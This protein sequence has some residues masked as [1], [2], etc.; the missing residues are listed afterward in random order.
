MISEAEALTLLQ[1][2]Q[3]SYPTEGQTNQQ[4]V[5]VGYTLV[6]EYSDGSTGFHAIV[7]VDASGNYVIAFTGTEPSGTDALADVHLGMTQWM[8]ST[9]AARLRADLA[10]ISNATSISFTGHSLGGGLA[11][12]AA[13]DYRSANTT[14]PMSLVTFNAFGGVQGI[15][16]RDATYDEGLMAGVESVHFVVEGDVVSRLGDGHIGGEVRLLDFGDLNFLAAHKLET[17]FLSAAAEGVTLTSAPTVSLDYLNIEAGQLIAAALSNLVIGST[18]PNSEAEAWARAAAGML[19]ALHYAP[20]EEVAPLAAALMPGLTGVDWEVAVISARLTPLSGATDVVAMSAA[21][22]GAA[23]HGLVAAQAVAQ[24]LTTDAMEAIVHGHMVLVGLARAGIELTAGAAAGARQAAVDSYLSTVEVAT[25]GIELLVNAYESAVDFTVGKLEDARALYESAVTWTADVF[26]AIASLYGVSLEAATELRDLL[27]A[28]GGRAAS[29]GLGALR[30]FLDDALGFLN[31]NAS[32]PGQDAAQFAANASGFLE[33]EG[34]LMDLQTPSPNDVREPVSDH[35]SSAQLFLPYR[36]DPL[37]VDLDEDGLETVGADPENPIYFDHDGDGVL[38]SSGWV[39][40]DDG[41]LVLDRNENGAIDDG[42]ELFGDSTPLYGGGIASNGFEALGQEDTNADGKVDSSDVNWADLK[43]W[44]DL[45]QDG[46]SQSAELFS[47]DGLGIVALNVASTSHSQV[48]A[49]GNR[50]ADLGSYV[51]VDG[52]SGDMGQ[53]SQTADIDL[54][55]DTFHS[56]FSTSVPITSEAQNLPNMDGS[57]QVR[58]LREAASLSSGLATLLAD[59]ASESTRDGQMALIDDIVDA[60]ANTS[61]MATTFGGAYAGHTLTVD[62]EGIVGGSAEYQAWADKLSILERFNGRTFNPVPEEPGS[63]GITLW[64]F[65]LELLQESYDALKASVYESLVLQTRLKPLVELV[66]VGFQDGRTFLDF[67]TLTAELE[68]RIAVDPAS[69][70]ADLMDFTIAAQDELPGWTG[71]SLFSEAVGGVQLTPEL[72]ASLAE[73]GV[74]VKGQLGYSPTGTDAGETLI[75]DL[76]ADTIASNAGNDVLLGLGGDDWLDGGAGDDVIDGGAGNDLLIGNVGNDFYVFTSSGGQDTVSDH[77]TI[78]GNIDIARLT[79]LARADVSMVREVDA[80]GN[81]YNLLIQINGT[82]DVL[83]I[84][85]QFTS[86]ANGIE[87]V[88]FDD[89]TTWDVDEISVAPVLP[90]M[91]GWAY[92]TS[93]ADWFDLR[94]SSDNTVFGYNTSLTNSGNDTYVFGAG[95]GEDAISDYG[96]DVGNVDIV[97]VI[98]AAPSNTKILRGVNASGDS[99]DLIIQLDGLPDRLSITGQFYDPAY[100]IEQVV[101]DDGTIWTAAQLD[102]APITPTVADQAANGTASADWF[103]LRN[104]TNNTFFGYN[105]GTNDSGNDTYLFGAGAGQD[106]ISDYGVV[107]GHSDTIKIVGL[108]ASEVTLLRGLNASGTANDLLIKVNGTADQLLVAGQFYSTNYKIEQIVFDDGTIWGEAQINAAP[109]PISASVAYGTAASDLFDLRNPIGSTVYGYNTSTSDSGDDTYIFGAGAGQDLISDYGS[110]SGN[111]DTIRLVGLAP[112]QV[113]MLREVAGGNA[114]TLAININ[115]TTDQLRIAGQFYSSAYAIERVLFD[116]GTIW[117][118]DEINTAPITP[119]SAGS[120]NGT[121]AADWFDLRAG[122]SNTFYGYNTSVSDSGNDT[123]IFGAGGGQDVISDY[124]VASG[125]VDTVRVIGLTA[126]QVSMTRAVDASGNSNNLV[127]RANDLPDQAVIAGQFYSSAYAIEQVVFDG[128]VWDADEINAAP[129]TPTAGGSVNGTAASDWF[130]TRESSTNT[131]FGYN[132]STSDSGNDTYLFGAGAGQD[133]ISDY[134]SAA[135]NIDTIRVTGLAAADVTMVR[136]VSSGNSNNLLIKVNGTSD[137]LRISGQ[138]YSTAYAVEQVVFDD[139]TTW[140]ADEINAAPVTPTAVGT[141][142]GSS[143]ADWFDLKGPTGN[144]FYGYNSS[145]AESGNDTYLFGIGGGADTVIDYGTASGNT[146][147]VRVS[148]G[149]ASDQ[150][151]FSHVGNNLEMSIIGLSD[152]LTLA[153]WYLGATY[154]AE[155]FVLADGKVLLESQVENLV[156][157]M[158]AFSPPPPGQ[159]TLPASYQDDLLPVIAANWQ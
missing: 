72:A 136:E 27:L 10:A 100:R 93:E 41:F 130:D 44:R 128:S 61:E 12:Y 94:A 51:T 42:T 58:S 6:S 40:A 139:G 7:S 112:S 54:E 78:V 87:E 88:I 16:G 33:I 116:D 55:E 1:A 158:A 65:T 68:N 157:A 77:D 153:G 121:A 59:F 2:S 28:E 9:E 92:G 25:D 22:V 115:G 80:N 56:E 99:H 144:T 104:S 111:L 108:A 11:Q 46:I 85:G 17:S 86:A 23:S 73:L 4:K 114:N 131:F 35:F 39:I 75:G 123:Y 29:S 138:F 67:A 97:R 71:W 47:L 154:R 8:E 81:S 113:S 70:I 105:T 89:G 127:I 3:N 152:K 31:S 24:T 19:F 53:T 34:G 145:A 135:G 124:G 142:N 74:K 62:M 32:T 43:V 133:T 109:V 20:A 96:S 66:Q 26:E 14:T 69:G 151:W 13:Y 18:V 110:T 120:I 82:T 50:L 141:V 38:T 5:P 126:S 122:A 37:V 137:Q 21:F 60:W 103:D 107:A 52:L 140:D 30:C 150:L 90:T 98:G 155:Q 36:A 64:S 15:T 156:Q 106:T 91:A 84:A 129:I 149:V 118:A 45:N 101:F 79:G 132:I 119:T 148:A 146:D 143:A 147:V 117:D 76:A 95:A 83:R 159:T 49:N 48:L 134:G 57:G 102:I 63:V 125:N